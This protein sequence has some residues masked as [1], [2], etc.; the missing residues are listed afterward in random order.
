MAETADTNENTAPPHERMVGDT[1][2]GTASDSSRSYLLNTKLLNS[3]CDPAQV[4]VSC[5]GVDRL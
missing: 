3:T 5:D 2:L 4:N 1:T